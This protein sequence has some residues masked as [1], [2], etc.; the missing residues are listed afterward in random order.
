MSPAEIGSTAC[1]PAGRF[2]FRPLVCSPEDAAL[3]GKL[4]EHR[5]DGCVA[6]AGDYGGHYGTNHAAFARAYLLPLLTRSSR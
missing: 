2:G 5:W 1:H 6:W 3:Y 4:R